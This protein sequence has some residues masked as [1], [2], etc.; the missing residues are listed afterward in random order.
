MADYPP[1]R[2]ADP[3]GVPRRIVGFE[4][5][6]DGHWVAQLDCSHGQHVRHAPPWQDRP[7]TQTAAGRAVHVGEMLPCRKCLD[8]ADGGSLAGAARTGGR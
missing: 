5:D 8:E 7:W 1:D 4:R 3:R 2:P 6:A